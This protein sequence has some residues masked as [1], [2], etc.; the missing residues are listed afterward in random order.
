M[1]E[2]NT[3]SICIEKLDTKIT[4][5]KCNHKFHSRCIL[6]YTLRCKNEVICPLCRD[7]IVKIL[8][9]QELVP[10]QPHVTLVIPEEETEIEDDRKKCFRTFL[11]VVPVLYIIMVI[12]SVIYQDPF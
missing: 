3:C 11:C 10:I 12:T 9:T 6:E 8:P 5:L 7:S 4:T 2:D 1:E